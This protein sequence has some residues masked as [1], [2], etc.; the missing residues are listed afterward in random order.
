MPDISW[1]LKVWDKA[2]AWIKDGDEWSEQAEACNVPYEKWK[3][4]LTR[5]K[6][7]V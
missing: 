2:Y 1:N 5:R 4:Q 6:S 7:V 3:D